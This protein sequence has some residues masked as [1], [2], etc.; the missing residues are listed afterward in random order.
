MFVYDLWEEIPIVLHSDS[1]VSKG[2]ERE[3]YSHLS[4]NVLFLSL[5][6]LMST[7]ID[8]HSKYMREWKVKSQ[9]S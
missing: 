4:F 6:I 9:N 7:I 2:E 1:L 5:S 8:L 3:P